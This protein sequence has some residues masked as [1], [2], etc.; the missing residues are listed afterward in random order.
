VQLW[1]AYAVCHIP[2]V[3]DV[4]DFSRVGLAADKWFDRIL[5]KLPDTRQFLPAFEEEFSIAELRAA[6]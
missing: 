2:E 6:I 3:A 4:Y 1:V 5:E